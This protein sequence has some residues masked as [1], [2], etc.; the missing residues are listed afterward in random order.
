[1]KGSFSLSFCHSLYNPASLKG[2]WNYPSIV[3]LFLTKANRK[4]CISDYYTCYARPLGQWSWWLESQGSNGWL[5]V[6]DS[7]EC[8]DPLPASGFLNGAP[9]HPL[10]CDGHRK[11]PSILSNLQ[12][13]IKRKR[14]LNNRNHTWENHNVK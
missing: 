6:L 9:Q 12:V 13:W 5:G 10:V 4:K 8:Q 14:F 1:M 3:I 7:S 2:S 11:L